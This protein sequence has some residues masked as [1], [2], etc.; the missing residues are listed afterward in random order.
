M[1]TVEVRIL[2]PQP[3]L[4]RARVL[5]TVGPP[6]NSRTTLPMPPSTFTFTVT[7]D[8]P[9]SSFTKASP[10][11]LNSGALIDPRPPSTVTRTPT[12]RGSL[13]VARPT[14]PSICASTSCFQLP[15]KSTVD[16]PAPI[17]TWSLAIDS[18]PSSRF[19]L[20]APSSTWSSSG[21]LLFNC[22]SHV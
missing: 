15:P 2:P 18:S 10:S 20:P 4:G 3:Q 19:D 5:Q 9:Y 7:G 16:S 1:Q 11:F 14:P 13:T 21:T 12:L 8:F 17:S 6:L 22:T